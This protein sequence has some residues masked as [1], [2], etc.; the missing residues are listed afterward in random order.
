MS[1]LSQGVVLRTFGTDL[2]AHELRNFQLF[3]RYSWARNNHPIPLIFHSSRC[4]WHYYVSEPESLPSPHGHCCGDRCLFQPPSVVVTWWC[5]VVSCWLRFLNPK[6][7]RLLLAC[8]LAEAAGGG[9]M[10]DV[11]H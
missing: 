6:S 8:P 9:A 7:F 1:N 2:G 3:C 4:Y 11:H 5:L 10:N